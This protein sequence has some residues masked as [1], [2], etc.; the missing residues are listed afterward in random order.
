MNN[1]W[2]L[3]FKYFSYH[4]FGTNY[5]KYRETA[6]MCQNR[7]ISEIFRKQN[8]DMANILLIQEW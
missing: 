4:M 7:Q 8:I 3:G 6:K 1:E 5:T 2:E